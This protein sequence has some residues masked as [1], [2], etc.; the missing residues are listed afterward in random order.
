MHYDA[1]IKD[2]AKQKQNKTKQKAQLP[3]QNAPRHIQTEDD[4]P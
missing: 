4:T 2:D 3:I 1:K